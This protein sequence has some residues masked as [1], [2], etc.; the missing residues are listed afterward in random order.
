MCDIRSDSSLP[1]N[2]LLKV[3]TL[4]TRAA[5]VPNSSNNRQ[6]ADYVP[7]ISVIHID[8]QCARY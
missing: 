7:K 2:N 1:G 4:P 6:G 5:L 3:G 8:S